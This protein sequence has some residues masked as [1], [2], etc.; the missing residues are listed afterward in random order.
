VVRNCGPATG[1]LVVMRPTKGNWRLKVSNSLEY[2]FKENR[3]SFLKLYKTL[4][5]KKPILLF[6]IQEQRIY[7][8]PYHEFKAQMSQKGQAVLE[9][10]YSH[11]LAET[12]IIAFARDNEQKRLVSN[13]IEIDPDEFNQ[14]D[15][16]ETVKIPQNNM[17]LKID[18]YMQVT[19]LVNKMKE[20]LPI[21]AYPTPHTKI[22]LRKQGVRNIGQNVQIS[23]V[24]YMG[25]E[26]G[27]SCQIKS[28]EKSTEVLIVSLTQLT[29]DPHHPL[30]KEIKS[31]QVTRRKK[32]SQSNKGNK[33]KSFTISPRKKRNKKK[34]KK[35]L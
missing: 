6:D 22:L 2:I 7:A 10:Q 3:I 26:A 12:H 9:E 31:Y 35:Q 14:I 33:T 21:P 16:N 5:D 25:D 20:A 1:E 15:I 34:T 18:N 24:V 19:E 28:Q 17:G 30:A 23:N 4:Q 32:L 13:L 29:V 27:I 11:V 8:Y